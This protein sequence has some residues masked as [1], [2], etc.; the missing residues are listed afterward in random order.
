MAAKVPVQAARPGSNLE[1]GRV[2]LASRGTC[3]RQAGTS[4]CLTCLSL[5]PGW[6]IVSVLSWFLYGAAREVAALRQSP[7]QEKKMI[8]CPVC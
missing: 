6:W 2:S 8:P 5:K 7:K 1:E 4:Y 3:Q